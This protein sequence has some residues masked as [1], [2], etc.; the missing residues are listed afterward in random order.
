MR[1]ILDEKK[2]SRARSLI[3][4]HVSG[5]K[6][7]KVRQGFFVGWVG[8]CAAAAMPVPSDTYCQI[9][10]FIAGHRLWPI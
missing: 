7:L 2:N 10:A 6:Y 1:K 8:S 3:S 5:I 9:R 4:S